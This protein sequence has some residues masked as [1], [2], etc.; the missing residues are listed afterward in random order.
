M[1]NEIK[2]IEDK[3]FTQGI[4]YAIQQVAYFHGDSDL[5]IWLAKESGVKKEEFEEAQELNG[6]ETEFMTENVLDKL[7]K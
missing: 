7:E 4:W 6:F 3:S 5:A 1:D 2:K